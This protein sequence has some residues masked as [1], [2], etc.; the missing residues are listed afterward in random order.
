MK[1]DWKN[2]PSW[3]KYL[4]MDDAGFW[5]WFERKP[6]ESCG[7]WASNYQISQAG[8]SKCWN[9]TLEARP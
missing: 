4:A 8:K 6:E 1:P 5:Y 7:F 3:A 2:A 9:E